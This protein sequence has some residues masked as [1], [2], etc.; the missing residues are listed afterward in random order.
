MLRH[1]CM[2]ERRWPLISRSQHARSD[3]GRPEACTPRVHRRPRASTALSWERGTLE[4]A[5]PGTRRTSRHRDSARCIRPFR[6]EHL[7]QSNVLRFRLGAAAFVI[8]YLLKSQ[9]LAMEMLLP[10]RM[11]ALALGVLAAHMQR[12]VPLLTAA[13]ISIGL[14]LLIYGT[15]FR[16]GSLWILLAAIIGRAVALGGDKRS[17]LC[18]AASWQGVAVFWGNL[19]WALPAASAHSRDFDGADC[20]RFHRHAE[21]RADTDWRAGRW[22]FGGAFYGLL[23]YFERPI[24]RWTKK[25]S[26]E[27]S[28][29]AAHA[30]GPG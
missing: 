9:P 4:N 7:S 13:L 3:L 16:C 5:N 17:R 25:R 24:I 27:P 28:L 8:R 12:T 21:P 11:D 20:G 15:A 10:C 30:L 6:L 18:R 19:V 29:A 1:G 22:R 26:A 23:R 14:L 2:A